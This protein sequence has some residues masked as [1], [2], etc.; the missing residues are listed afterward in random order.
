MKRHRADIKRK[1]DPTID[2]SVLDENGQIPLDAATTVAE[3]VPISKTPLSGRELENAR[4]VV[5]DARHKVELVVDHAWELT[6]EDWL[7]V[8]NSSTGR[9]QRLNIGDIQP[10]DEHEYEFTLICTEPV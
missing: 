4:Q 9:S 7:M 6:P 5:A 8:T 3:S 10:T 2:P 1:P